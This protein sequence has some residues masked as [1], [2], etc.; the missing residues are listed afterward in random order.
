MLSN[1]CGF[2]V[3]PE[4][5]IVIRTFATSA[6]SPVRSREIIHVRATFTG[7][8]GR[9]FTATTNNHITVRKQPDGSLVEVEN[10]RTLFLSGRRLSVDGELLR[11]VG[12]TTDV[13][14]YCAILAP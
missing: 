12:H 1:A 2:T 11:V 3:S 6:A 4:M 8:T 13:A 10:G 5:H 7:P 14:E 9:S